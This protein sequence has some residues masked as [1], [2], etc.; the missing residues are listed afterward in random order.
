MFGQNFLAPVL[1]KM[2]VPD[3]AQW[4][5]PTPVAHFDRSRGLEQAWSDAYDALPWPPR[6]AHSRRFAEPFLDLWRVPNDAAARRDLPALFL[7][8]THVQT[9]RRL[10]TTNLRA[11]L[12]DAF[13]THET[14]GADLSLASAVHNSARFTYVS[15]AGR[16]LAHNGS[17]RGHVVDGGY[18]ETS[19]ATTLRDVLSALG[20][21]AARKDVRFVVLHTC[22]DPA[23]CGA[24]LSTKSTPVSASIPEAGPLAASDPV[25]PLLALFTTWGA[26]AEA[27]VE[28]L[29]TQVKALGG[30]RVTFAV[31]PRADREDV[32]PLG[33]QLSPRSQR[34]LTEQVGGVGCSAN[35]DALQRVQT[36]LTGGSCA[37]GEDAGQPAAEAAPVR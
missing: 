3:L 6:P 17:D 16:L 1:A 8:G 23:A 15:P 34:I 30:V 18:F 2:L 37:A 28:D 20:T 27:A 11:A 26:R 19:G 25:A 22:N 32:A 7:N 9:G 36:C 4:F 5:W 12:R 21:S 13:D 35:A 29:T 33:W 14:L 31:C 24:Y 10:V